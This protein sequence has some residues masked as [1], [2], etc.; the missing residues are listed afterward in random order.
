MQSAQSRHLAFLILIGITVLPSSAHAYID[1]G[2]GSVFLQIVLGG[3]S[4]LLVLLKLYWGRVK[5]FFR[6]DKG[7]K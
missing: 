5:S 2:S 6:R 3:V 4:G 7:D 1:P